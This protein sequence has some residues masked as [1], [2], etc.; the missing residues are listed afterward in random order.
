MELFLKIVKIILKIRRT[1]LE[2]NKNNFKQSVCRDVS[3]EL[4]YMIKLYS[5]KQF[6]NSITK[7]NSIENAL[8]YMNRKFREHV[9]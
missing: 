8:F 4:K 9:N 2:H 7:D 5:L 3:L 1:Q 6:H